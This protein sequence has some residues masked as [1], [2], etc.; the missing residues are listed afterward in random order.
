MCASGL[1]Y[2]ADAASQAVCAGV[3]HATYPHEA[4]S[5]PGVQRHQLGGCDLLCLLLLGG[6]LPL[7]RVALAKHPGKIVAECGGV[8]VSWVAC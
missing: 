8:T 4:V 1:D 3:M 2:A 7:C 6:V 5:C